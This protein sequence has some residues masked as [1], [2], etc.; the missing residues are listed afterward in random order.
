MTTEVDKKLW[1]F[2][3]PVVETKIQVKD[4]SGLF[5]PTNK[6][7]AI[8]REDNNELIAIQKNTYQLVTNAEVIKPVLEQLNDL[9]TDWYIDPSHSFV[10]NNRMRLQITF[11]EI[12]LH[13][14]E[15]EIAL[16]LFV[17]NSYDSSEGVRMFWGGIRSI[18]SN[19]SVFG[20]VLAKFYAKHTSG[21]IVN[22]LK[23]QIEDTYEQIPLIKERISILQNLKPTSDYKEQI[24]KTF[25]KGI[26]EYV[27]EQPKVKNQWIL[28]NQL[29][30]YISH[31]VQQRMRASYQMKVSKMFQ[32]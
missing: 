17:H 26:A 28:Y 5:F 10:E 7:K 22:N 30:H 21:I 27:E 13:D 8:I 19:G 2:L 11:P 15:S 24:Q 9:T 18:C 3:F 31:F 12:T 16:S 20:E 1:K 25:G 29:T 4:T 14:G 6:Y 32:L 23:Q